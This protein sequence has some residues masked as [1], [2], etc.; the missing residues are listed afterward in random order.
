MTRNR[1]LCIVLLCIL[2]AATLPAQRNRITRTVDN[3]QRV[4]LAGNVHPRTRNAT[5]QGAVDSS[6]ILPHVTI[7]MKQSDS[8]KAELEQLLAE[9]ATENNVAAATTSST[10]SAGS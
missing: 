6:M 10:A 4:V 8:Q 2:A 1:P 9:Q 5:D 7:V 3:R